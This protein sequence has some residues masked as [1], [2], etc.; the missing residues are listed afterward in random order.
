MRNKKKQ[1]QQ[2]W[3][4]TCWEFMHF[5]KWKQELI[6]KLILVGFALLVMVWQTIKEEQHHAYQIAV[7]LSMAYLESSKSF[8]F[9]T[10]DT[11]LV[12]LNEQLASTEK[13]DA[14]IVE[15]PNTDDTKQL[16]ILSKDKQ[17]WQDDLQLHLSQQLSLYYAAS[18]G[19]SEPQ[20]STLNQP[21]FFEK[22]YLDKRIKSDDNP[23]STTA[24]GMIV[25]LFIAVFTSFGQ[26]FVSITGEKQQR[27]TEQLTACIS[28]QTWIDGKISGQMLHAIKAMLTA[29]IT[30]LLVY[31]FTTVVI[32]NSALDLS[33][34]DWTLLPWLLPFTITGVYLCTAFM[35][36]IAAAIDDPNHSAKTSIMLLPLLPLIL[37]F[38]TMDSPSG[39][40]LSFLSFFPITSFAAMP[41]KMSLIDV[42]IWHPLLSLIFIIALCFFIRT[43]A[44][45]LFKMGMS[46]YGKEPSMRDLIKWL[47]NAN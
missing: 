16:R 20:L 30:G 4:V 13:W 2:L 26:L 10:T 11:P 14:I 33:I 46:M 7:P 17:S 31:A 39:W 12:K 22:Q 42:P 44:G 6:S 25:L 19:L 5:F 41:V 9:T 28:A 43:A 1:R 40:A 35:A 38:M 45:R 24:I 27:V 37:T 32:N 23:G 3:L 34:I 47:F 18:L 15:K 8:N 21:V 29:A 36:A